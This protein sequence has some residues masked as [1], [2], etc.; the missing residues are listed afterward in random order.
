MRVLTAVRSAIVTITMGSSSH[1]KCM[2]TPHSDALLPLSS[3]S[4]SALSCASIEPAPFFIRTVRRPDIPLLADMLVKSFHAEDSW[5]NWLY[6]LL[7]AG[8][9]EDLKSRLHSRGPY[10]ACLVAIQPRLRDSFTPELV[11]RT[12]AIA[13]SLLA[14]SDSLIGTIELSVKTPSILQPWGKKYL[15]L[16]NLAVRED[17]RRQG[18]AQKL[19]QTCEKTAFDWGFRDLYLHVLENNH[20]ARRLYWKAGYRLQRIEVHPLTLMLGKPR[21]LFLHKR[22]T[23]AKSS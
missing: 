3:T 11:G 21:Q 18:V 19:L 2:S 13:L 20:P 7:K 16:S 10:F 5:M 4:S 9:H 23:G 17:W 6:P 14:Q 12:N 8:I 22:L 1:S 15:Y